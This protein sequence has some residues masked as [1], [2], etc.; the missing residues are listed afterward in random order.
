MV[1]ERRSSA[2]SRMVTSG[3]I[4]SRITLMLENSGRSTLSVTLSSRP[5]C[6][7]MAACMEARVKN[8]KIV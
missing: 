6:G 5:I 3:I 7:F 2:N 1:P 4:S 8:A